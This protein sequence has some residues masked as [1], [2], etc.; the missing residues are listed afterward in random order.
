MKDMHEI[1]LGEHGGEIRRLAARMLLDPSDLIDFSSSINPLGPPAAVSKILLGSER[2]LAP[3]P[4]SACHALRNAI[5][6]RWDV[7]PEGVL[8][9][10]G[11]TEL[12]FLIARAFRPA[13]SA[14][15]GPT[16]SEYERALRLAGSSVTDIGMDIARD[17]QWAPSRRDCDIL[18]RSRLC[19]ICNPNNPSGTVLP[20]DALQRVIAQFPKTLFVIDEAFVDFLQ[21]PQ[22]I[23]MVNESQRQSNLIVLRSTTKFFSIAGLRLGYAVALPSLIRV[24]E[25][26]KEPWSVNALAQAVGEGLLDEKEFAAKTRDWLLAEREWLMGELKGRTGL[27]PL[28]SQV[29]YLLLK[30]THKAITSGILFRELLKRRVVIRDA[31]NFR[32]L[33]TSFIRVAI[34]M[35][36]QNEILLRSLDEVLEACREEL[37]A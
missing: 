19:F 35:R 34:R 17:F 11:S 25:H 20:K 1:S 22:S 21:D 6:R 33:N 37:L 2:I 16:F 23:S 5:G 9:G 29:N 26:H 4:D 3:Y 28:P 31:S 36:P 7:A 13:T 24:L 18:Q 32:G 14:I 27:M 15:V 10:N 8:P 30:I 12:I